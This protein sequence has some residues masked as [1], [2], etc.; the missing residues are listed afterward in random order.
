MRAVELGSTNEESL[1]VAKRIANLMEELN[2]SLEE[3]QHG[4]NS[5]LRPVVEGV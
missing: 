2:L 3:V 5:S 4:G 1:E